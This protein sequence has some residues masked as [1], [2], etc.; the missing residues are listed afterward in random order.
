VIVETL[1]EDA[2]VGAQPFDAIELS[3]ASLWADVTIVEPG[4][5]PDPG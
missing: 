4:S 2:A 3:L 1:G 5:A